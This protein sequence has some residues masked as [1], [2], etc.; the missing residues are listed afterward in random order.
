[1]IDADIVFHKNEEELSL[2]RNKSMT[3]LAKQK[4]DVTGKPKALTSLVEIGTGPSLQN[5]QLTEEKIE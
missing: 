1:M 3:S 4:H 2:S 5:S